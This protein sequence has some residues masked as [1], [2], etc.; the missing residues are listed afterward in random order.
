MLGV[1][2]S[3]PT[4]SSVSQ[5]LLGWAGVP[6]VPDTVFFLALLGLSNALVWPSIWPLALEGLGKYTAAGSAC[7]SWA[8]P[9]VR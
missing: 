8:S 2:L 6:P 1:A 7:S 4:T 9:A 3:S 5:A